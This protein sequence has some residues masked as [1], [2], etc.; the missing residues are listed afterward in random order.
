MQERKRRFSF[1]III[2][3]ILFYITPTLFAISGNPFIT[4]FAPENII[5]KRITC[6]EA[7]SSG[8]M[9]L[10]TPSGVIAYNS[11]SWEM[12]KTPSGVRALYFQ[13]NTGILYVG[14]LNKIG[15]ITKNETGVLTFSELP[16]SSGN[17]GS[18]FNITESTADIIFH[19]HNKIIRLNKA[20]EKISSEWTVQ[21]D[22][23]ID[24]CFAFNN[25]LYVVLGNTGLNTLGNKTLTLINSE[26]SFQPND[27]IVFASEINNDTALLAS[28]NGNIYLLSNNQL[29]QFNYDDYEYTRASR[30]NSGITLND[31]KSIVLSTLAGGIVVIDHSTGKTLN[32]INYKSGIPDDEIYSIGLDNSGGIWASHLYGVSRIDLNFPV[33]SFHNYNGLNG[34]ILSIYRSDTT[35]LVGTNEGLFALT[36]QKNYHIEKISR[37]IRVKV[38]GKD[39]P[40]DSIP[41]SLTPVQ[42]T[43]ETSINDTL[44]IM[45]EKKTGRLSKFFKS[46]KREDKQTAT[47]PEEE[48]NTKNPFRNQ[49]NEDLTKR[50][51][52]QSE[53]FYTTKRVN[54]QVYK[55]Q[56]ISRSFEKVEG[57]NDKVKDIIKLGDFYLLSTNTGLYYYFEKK[58]SLLLEN[59]YIEE[60][61]ASKDSA[62]CFVL[63]R[64]GI[65][66]I[67]LKDNRIQSSLLFEKH[68]FKGKGIVEDNAG[69]IWVGSLDELI[70][71]KVSD[72]H[73]ISRISSP[74]MLNGAI[75]PVL[76]K[77][78]TLEIFNEGVMY[79]WFKGSLI[80]YNNPEE[81]SS[82]VIYQYYNSGGNIFLTNG[83]D[84][85]YKGNDRL[86]D[87]SDIVKYL[88]LFTKISA[89]FVDDVHNIWIID[90]YQKLYKI[91]SAEICNYNSDL[92]LSI[93]YLTTD[94]GLMFS[95]DKVK[96]EQNQ[97][98]VTI[99]VS[100][101]FFIKKD[102]VQYSY[103]IQNLSETWSDWN[104][105]P[106]IRLPR[107]PAGKFKISVKA[108]NI[109]GTESHIK[110]FYIRVVPPFWKTIWFY[111]L[112]FLATLTGIF[113]IV[114]YREAKLLRTQKALEDK[115][116]ERTREIERQ[117]DKIEDQAYKITDSI[118]YAK[119]IQEALLPSKRILKNAAADS[120]ILYQP[121]DIVSGDFYWTHSDENNLFI[122][123]ADCTGHGVPGAL[124][125][126][127]G[128]S[129]LNDLIKKQGLK[130]PAEILNHTRNLVIESLNQRGNSDETKDG[131]DIAFCHID[132]DKKI[133]NY[134]GAY[135]PLLGVKES[136]DK[137][138]PMHLVK[139]NRTAVSDSCNKIVFQI[140]ADR[141]P[142]S[143][144]IRKKGDFTTRS[145]E[146]KPGDS[147]YIFSDG[148]HDQFGE[149]T[150]KRYFSGRFRNKILEICNKPMSEQ[151]EILLKELSDWKGS[152]PQTDD[153]LIIGFKL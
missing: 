45:K 108:R 122:A 53:P 138:V 58:I 97:S 14:L 77:N 135:N 151:K 50:N 146:Y 139:G 105:N 28:E 95:P 98:N 86:I 68:N 41:A 56:S 113:F 78:D 76:L 94:E 3:T 11:E 7:G 99:N 8:N 115:V 66:N 127:L 33:E 110:S 126:V 17:S 118:M 60:I 84:W 148:Y 16:L 125:S 70:K 124:M 73:E 145:F 104:T 129:F 106:N 71:I 49:F 47:A 24:Y 57:V 67:E 2:T 144:N 88:T 132:F 109:F 20:E 6:I 119:R 21:K 25:I 130:D 142:V 48:P 131:M 92:N 102:A 42:E 69:N 30:I 51:K 87:T 40:E 150:G 140:E 116:S 63:T 61:H 152:T 83:R 15:K 136:T 55:L 80:P 137:T 120:F 54:E 26:L 128:I 36:T 147:F 81:E 85:E 90:N 75:I 149:Q 65:F 114:R 103:Y 37:L 91:K 121:R 34:N 5:E 9:F 79:S 143:S 12:I 39:L 27:K 72:A 134:A 10:G 107:L 89:V 19:S 101:A 23:R 44:V 35:F 153:I 62:R 100:A 82:P 38:P 112:V 74:G 29:L 141:M 117:K 93:N 18:F 123:A 96:L 111:I 133:I 46:F 52:K 22:D 32:I 59:Q 64:N 1:L 43:P 13:K 4:N 31:K